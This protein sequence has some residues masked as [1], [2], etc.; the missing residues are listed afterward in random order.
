MT[1]EK[2]ITQIIKIVKLTAQIIL[3]NGGE[4]YR[5]ED[6]AMRICSSFGLEVEPV[7]MPTGLFITISHDGTDNHTII[8]RVRRRTVNLAK[9]DAANGISRKITSRELTLNEAICQL[10]ELNNAQESPRLMTIFASALSA[11]FFTL[12]FNG[13]FFDFAIAALCGAV[14]QITAF[15]L[16]SEDMSILLPA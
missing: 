15:L 16:Q 7:A 10:E 14:I 11:G 3:E 4:T 12:L 9:V 13:S 6:T 5:V 2:E 1:K 8:K